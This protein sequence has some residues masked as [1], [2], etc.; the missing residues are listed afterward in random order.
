MSERRPVTTR[1]LRG[2][3]VP[4][5]RI[6]RY[7][8]VL[9][10]TRERYHPDSSGFPLAP[11]PKEYFL[12]CPDG[13]RVFAQEWLPEEP[14]AILLCQHG[15]SIQS[16]LFYPLADH[17]FPRGV[18]VVAIDNRGHGRS[19]PVRGRL[20]DPELVYP[21]YEELLGRVRAE[22]PGAPR[23]LLGESLG[24]AVVAGYLVAGSREARSVSS[25]I[26]QVPPFRLRADWILKP[27]RRIVEFLLWLSRFPSLDHPWLH[28]RPDPAQSYSPEFRALDHLDPVRAPKTASL[29]LLTA[30]R[31]IARFPQLV[32][33][34]R[35][36][37]LVLEGSNDRILDPRGALDLARAA[38]LTRRRIVVYRG[39][40]HSLF[41]DTHSRGVYDEIATWLS[42]GWS[43]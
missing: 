41:H 28:V 20:Q 25:A 14:S 1:F 5:E 18:G 35:V 42:G 31:L 38:T 19:G 33:R 40:D 13:S 34:L 6:R 32:P 17:L 7:Y 43:S 30:S 3:G 29:H 9:D 26:L 39:A 12:E 11:P 2:L 24:C 37:L 16:D 27:L 21:V 8:E 15:N 22:F 23:H 36:P 10:A 4:E